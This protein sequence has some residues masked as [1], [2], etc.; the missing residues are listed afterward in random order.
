MSGRKSSEVSGLLQQCK[1]ARGINEAN[2]YKKT[3]YNLETAIRNQ[4]EINKIYDYIKQNPIRF[5]GQNEMDEDLTFI[6]KRLEEM[7]SRIKRDAYISGINVLKNRWKELMKE[8]NKVDDEAEN[9]RN[10]IANKPHYCDEEYR[11]ASVLVREYQRITKQILNIVEETDNLEEASTWDY[12]YAN[13]IKTYIQ[14][15]EDYKN[16]LHSNHSEEMVEA[17]ENHD[18]RVAVIENFIGRINEVGLDTILEFVPEEYEAVKNKVDRL[19]EVKA[20]T[21][22]LEKVKEDIKEFFLT[23]KLKQEEWKT[24]KEDLDRSLLRVQ[25][26]AREDTYYDPLDYAENG[27]YANKL[28]LFDF[29]AIYEEREYEENFNIS[30]EEAKVRLNIGDLSGAADCIAKASEMLKQASQAAAILQE[31]MVKN[32][33][34]AKDMQEAMESLSYEVEVSCIDG[35]AK[36]GIKITCSLGD[37]QIDFDKVLVQEEGNVIVDINHIESRKG[38]CGTSW[39]KIAEVMREYNIPITDVR[40][41]GQSLLYASQEKIRLDRREVEDRLPL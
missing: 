39:K 40:K 18:D 26:Q 8:L 3:G 13:Q 31:N 38:T 16:D 1:R 2:W 11:R 6:L 36:N 28:H 41:N 21:I 10:I 19:V 12:H 7:T 20:E 30:M 32:I 14:Q 24:K 23:L 5:D 17:D 33:Y 25:K 35:N 34:L 4:E 27:K 15:L 9:I 37:E 29:L 22:E